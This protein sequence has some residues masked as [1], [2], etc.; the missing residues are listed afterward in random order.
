M[1]WSLR[2]EGCSCPLR[3]RMSGTMPFVSVDGR[4]AFMG[5]GGGGTPISK[6]QAL[7]L[8]PDLQVPGVG[9]PT[10]EMGRVC[11]PYRDRGSP[12]A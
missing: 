5:Q 11:P 6:T 10:R 9:T 7:Y 3:H 2:A 1:L 12:A 4:E 8:L